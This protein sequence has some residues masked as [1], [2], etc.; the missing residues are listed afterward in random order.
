[1]TTL[2][3]HRINTL[4]LNPH[5]SFPSERHDSAELIKEWRREQRCKLVPRPTE[6]EET[7]SEAEDE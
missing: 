3:A 5:A 6:A 2:L 4:L 7:Q 1:M